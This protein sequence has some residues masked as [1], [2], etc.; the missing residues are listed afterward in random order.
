MRYSDGTTLQVGA[1]CLCRLDQNQEV[2]YHCHI[3]KMDSDGPC[4]VF[5]EE[6]GEKRIVDFSQLECL[7]SDQL[8]PWTPPYRFSRAQSQFFTISQILQQLGLLI[9]FIFQSC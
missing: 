7:P 8:Q 3:Q 9:A 4:T 6:L 1:K 2:P 5:I